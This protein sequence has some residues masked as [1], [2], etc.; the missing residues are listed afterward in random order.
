[1]TSFLDILLDYLNDIM[2]CEPIK[3]LEPLLPFIPEVPSVSEQDADPLLCGVC[4]C[5]LFE[6]ISLLTGQSVCKYCYTR[7]MK[8]SSQVAYS[9][10]VCLAGVAERHISGAYRAM[11]LRIQGN[12]MA[13]EV[14]QPVGGG[15]LYIIYLL[16]F[17]ETLGRGRLYL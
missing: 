9:V 2:E 12:E 11:E 15:G 7:T 3:R 10:N 6:P 8:S 14:P 5:I 4:H 16:L 1:M 13:R 17:L